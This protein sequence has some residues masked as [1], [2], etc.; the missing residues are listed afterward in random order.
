[1]KSFYG[2]YVAAEQDGKVN[3]NRDVQDNWETWTVVPKGTHKFAF[4]SYHGKYLVAE[5]N[6]EVR[7]SRDVADQWETFV[8][9]QLGNDVALKTHHNTY[10]SADNSGSLMTKSTLG[11]DERFSIQCLDG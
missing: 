3:A 7:A 4:K 5:T 9:E 2:K 1:M 10:L 11:D 6:G 8:L